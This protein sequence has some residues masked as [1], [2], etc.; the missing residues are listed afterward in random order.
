MAGHPHGDELDLINPFS[1]KSCNCVLSSASSLGG[2][3]YDLLEIGVV[4]CFG[5]ITN[6]TSVGDSFSNAMN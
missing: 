4:L 2:I 1:N 3:R 6:Y 5:S